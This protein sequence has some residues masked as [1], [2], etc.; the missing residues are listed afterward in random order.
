MNKEELKSE[1][2]EYLL[3]LDDRNKDEWYM[4]DRDLSKNIITGFLKFVAARERKLAKE[5]K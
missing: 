1:L 4:T 3:T 2:K 5:K